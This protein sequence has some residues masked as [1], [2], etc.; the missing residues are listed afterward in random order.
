[1]NI[2]GTQPKFVVEHKRPVQV[3]SRMR[4]VRSVRQHEYVLLKSDL[5]LKKK[6]FHSVEN[7]SQIHA[8]IQVNFLVYFTFSF[9][10]LKRHV[11]SLNWSRERIARYNGQMWL[12]DRQFI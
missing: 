9:F 5:K 8:F 12:Q 10:L 4:R 6:L 1:M 7:F 3:F 2:T 11:R